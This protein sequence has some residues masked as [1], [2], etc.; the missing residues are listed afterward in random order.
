M[1]RTS[2]SPEAHRLLR[3]TQVPLD[4]ISQTINDRHR[5][6][7]IQ[8]PPPRIG[9]FH[10]FGERI[11]FALGSISRWR[12]EGPNFILE[13][14]SISLIL[15]LQEELPAGR[16]SPEMPYL[17]ILRVI[18]QSFGLPLK[19]AEGGEP[20]FFIEEGPWGGT[21][22]V[23]D[24]PK[25]GMFFLQG[26]FNT[27]ERRCWHL[28]AFSIE[29]YLSWFL[30]KHRRRSRKEPGLLG[31]QEVQQ[32]HDQ[33]LA[34]GWDRKHFE[35]MLNVQLALRLIRESFAPKWYDHVLRQHPELAS[36][37]YGKHT[38]SD[39]I[40]PLQPALWGGQP[41]ELLSIV[42][43]GHNLLDFE[44]EIR[45]GTLGEKLR[46]LS[47]PKEFEA[48]LFELCIASQFRRVGSRVEFVRREP[49]RTPDMRVDSSFSVECKRKSP[50]VRDLLIPAEVEAYLGSIRSSIIEGADQLASAGF[51]GAVFLET[52]LNGKTL[53]S[54]HPRC[55]RLTEDAFA[56]NPL[57]VSVC[58][59]HNGLLDAGDAVMPEGSASFFFSPACPTGIREGL[60]GAFG[61]ALHME[62]LY[63]RFPILRSV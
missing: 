13:E 42:R 2:L 22:E 49:G 59:V 61:G 52:A 50:T 35:N 38:R 60:Q 10:W 39:A 57:L 41:G 5:G 51:P 4:Q 54:M 12:T 25:G 34:R 16:I 11:V 55:Q 27:R 48:A 23:L 1:I 44:E 24:P 63:D 62:N 3:L 45:V 21:L 8:G 47:K 26:G 28:W 14:V 30:T 17:D 43:L 53:A 37:E 33:F 32:W 15:D 40:H 18:T 6:L 58:F 56:Q 36:R 31:T 19:S 9:A 7:L 46:Q 29:K 20:S